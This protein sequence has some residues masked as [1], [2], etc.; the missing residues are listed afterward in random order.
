MK[1]NSKKLLKIAPVIFAI[2]VVLL[3][4]SCDGSLSDYFD[5]PKW[6]GSSA[7][8]TLK[9]KGNYKLFLE[10]VDKAGY[11]ELIDGNSIVTVM[12]PNDEA[13]NAYLKEN[14]YDS[15]G[16]IP[17]AELDKLVGFH[18]LYYAFNT[19]KLTNFRPKE[20]DDCTD[21]EKAVNAGMYYKFRTR[22]RDANTLEYDVDRKMNLTV[23]HF[24]RY[25]P[26]FSYNY[27]NTKK[28][29]AKTNYEYFFP[30]TEWKGSNGF[31]VSNAA[32]NDYE[33]ITCNGYVYTIDKVLS[34]IKTIYQ[35][36]QSHNEFSSFLSLYDKYGYY[37]LDQDLTQEYGNGTNLYLHYHSSPLAN[38]ALEWP[39]SNYAKITENS[40]VSY[41]VFAPTNDAI[42][43]FFTNYW[44]VGGYDSLR[45]VS[46]TSI[47]K[48]L[49]NCV[50]GS[51]L[52][53]PE[54]ISTGRVKNSYNAVISFDVFSENIVPKGYRIMCEN[55]ALYGCKQL[56]VPAMFS[57]VTGPSYQYKK[58]AYYLQ[59]LNCLG[60]NENSLWSKD[61]RYLS[62]MPSNEQVL[63]AGFY[64]NPT[65]KVLCTDAAG[66]T[67]FNDNSYAYAHMID[68]ASTPGNYTDFPNNKY[69]I[70]RTLSPSYTL[71]VYSRPGNNGVQITNS[72]KYNERIY[73]SR[74][75]EDDVFFDT[76]ELTYK[77]GE[78]SNGKSY[79]YDKY[80]F[81]GNPKDARI[82]Y[83][84]FAGLMYSGSALDETLPY[85]GFYNLMKTA[86]LYNQRS[87]R[88][89]TTEKSFLML[90][91]TT[92]A[93]EN[94]LAN[95]GIPG[96][97]L[98]D[99]YTN[100]VSM[101][102][103]LVVT[104]RDALQAYLKN[105]FIPLSTAGISNYPFLGWGE[106]T[107]KGMQTLNEQEIIDAN[108]RVTTKITYV[109]VKDFGTSLKARLMESGQSYID[110]VPDYHYFPFIFTDGCVQFLEKC[111]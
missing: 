10:A 7:Y 99:T 75:S 48:L 55:G 42:N 47:Q 21:E 97:R 82:Q 104:D 23:Y 111:F 1:F 53:F 5:K 102:K 100:T 101:F 106:D 93:V 98:S 94:A 77:G 62:L 31:N 9:D 67:K 95:N 50:Y 29:D 85:A 58:Y 19:D 45:E 74:S 32:V 20:G 88:F 65:T 69:G 110:L 109:E 49:Y 26:V 43:D 46:S 37:S 18:I 54:E 108:N 35:E 59:M 105:Y 22:S 4:S 8:Q 84:N 2:G 83:P 36:L 60:T 28:I 64:Y 68:L 52:V 78:W 76:H 63:N 80:L 86:G 33:L 61:A 79:A 66:T 11:K 90:I 87:F 39:E 16:G 40:S 73:P 71:Y 44:K 14:R 6:I 72:Y 30:G 70:F 17:P 3:C 91:P 89:L 41:S 51:A 38:I 81:V 56:A 107:S 34:P 103:Q 92:S 15:I 25:L 13:F 57:S 27:F 12:A 96:I 24:E